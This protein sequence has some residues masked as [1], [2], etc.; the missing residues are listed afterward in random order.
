M[1]KL[2]SIISVILLAGCAASTTGLRP[3]D[4][5]TSDRLRAERTLPLSFVQVQQ[6]VLKHKSICGQG[7]EF[8]VDSGHP[9]LARV[10]QK[11]TPDAQLEHSLVMTLILRPTEEDKFSVKTHV[12]S[13]YAVSDEQVQQLY[14]AILRPEEC[15]QVS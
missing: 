10:I 6:A 3:N 11:L 2:A 5:E 13:Y 7:P 15:P 12:Y 1:K 14:A 8:A 4:L 9:G